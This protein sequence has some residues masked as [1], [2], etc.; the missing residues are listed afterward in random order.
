MRRRR[1][2]RSLRDGRNEPPHL[3]CHSPRSRRRQSAPTPPE[4]AAPCLG[5][6]H[7]NPARREGAF[8]RSAFGP[9]RDILRLLGAKKSARTDVRGYRRDEPL[10]PRSSGR[11]S[12]LASSPA[13][14]VRL[15]PGRHETP[16]KVQMRRGTPDPRACLRMPPGRRM[17]ACGL[18]GTVRISTPCRPGPLAGRVLKQALRRR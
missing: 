6:G 8:A 1:H 11:Q 17:R 2:T 13:R 5:A 7:L 9:F 15:R 14:E 4:N 12:A 18:Q 10:P 3:G 16:R